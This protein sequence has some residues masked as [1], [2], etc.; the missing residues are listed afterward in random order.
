MKKLLGVVFMLMIMAGASLAQVQAGQGALAGVVQDST[1]AAIPGA[2]V[3]LSNPSIGFR[4]ETVTNGA[5]EYRFSPLTVIGG[6]SIQVTSP[7][8]AIA[9]VN[10][11][12]TSVGTIITE[13]VTLSVGKSDVIIEVKASGEEQVQTDTSSVSTVIDKTVWQD[14]PLEDRNQ[15]GFVG[16]TAGAAPS[17]AGRGFAVNGAR[18]GTGD[19]LVDGADNNDQG[20]GGGATGGAVTTISPDAIQEF[21]VISSTPPAEY[22]RAGGFATDTVLRS[23]SKT[24]HGSAF[25][26]N[27][28]QAITANN[29]ESGHNGLVD[30]LVRNQFGGSVGGRIY[31]D[32][33]F[34]YATA[35]FQRLRQG[36]PDAGIITTTP[37]FLNFVK[38]GAFETF[39][40]GTTQQIPDPS[41]LT[42]GQIGACPFNLGTSC[43]GV[44]ARSATLGP[45]FTQ[46]LAAEPS[47]FPLATSTIPNANIGEGLYTSGIT[48][49]VNVYGQVAVIDT[50]AY[51]ENRGSLKLDHKLTEKDQLSFTYLADLNNGNY[52]HGAGGSTPGV[53]ETTVG[54]AQLFG[55]N[56]TRT[57]SPTLIN[58]FKAGYLR[59][60]NNIDA[61]NAAGVPNI[62]PFD[63]L[64]TGF[65]ASSGLP[66][67][68]TEN[69]FSYE[70]S[71]TKVFGR[72]T[73]KVGFSFK[74]TR[75]GS[76]FYND[77]NGSIYPW[78]VEGLVTDATSDTDLDNYFYGTDENGNTNGYG[79]LA[80]A[81][82]SLNPT[83]NSA[84][85]PYRGYRANEF[86]AYVQDDF[87]V[88]ARLTLNY[89]VRWD[90]FG[91][92]HNFKAGV[93]SN[94]YFGTAT[95]PTPNGNP[96]LPNSSLLAGEQGASFQ[97][98]E[99]N[100]RST[101]WNRDTNNFAPRLGF[102][103]D[104][105]GTQK[106]VI[107]GGFGI[108]YDRLYNNVYE[109]IRFNAPFFVDNVGG[110]DEG[111]ASLGEP[112]RAGLYKVPFTGNAIL[113][114]T[115]AA[116]PRHVDQ[117]LVTAYYEQAH[118]GVETNLIKGFVLEVNY[119]G[120]W[121][122]KLVGI[123]NINTFAGRTACPVK[124]TPYAA[125][126]PCFIASQS[127]GGEGFTSA[128]PS[129][130]FGSDNFRTSSFSSNYNGGQVSLRKGFSHGFQISANYTYSKGLD[131]TSDV[132]SIKSGA[133][134]IT[135][136]YNPSYDYGPSDNDV[137][138][139]FILTANYV[140]ESKTHKYLLAGWGV[141]PIL[142]LQAGSPIDVIDGSSSYSPNKD[143]VFGVQRAVYV[144]TGSIK[145]AIQHGI[146]PSD[147][148]LKPGSFSGSD[149][150][151]SY[152]CPA[153]VAFC[154]APVGRNALTGPKQENLDMSVSKH[155]PIY[156]RYSLTL[157]AAFFDVFNHPEWGN[158]VANTNAGN[159]GQSTS[160]GNR[161]GQLSGRIDF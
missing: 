4:K 122:R 153:T 145:N 15:N 69:Q 157:Q 37:D 29:W 123:K 91:P 36:Q 141:S 150:V 12:E 62:V 47:S 14:S 127:T 124:T 77:V 102:A 63:S 49:P 82:A 66:Q 56:Y 84:P 147:G 67:Y 68:F 97:L 99:T 54:G 59:H 105:F 114:G 138:H 119:I 31:K 16:L 42:P 112:Q 89:G 1:K 98:A 106:L 58:V 140:S 113:S 88:S 70:D 109:N 74:R 129:H 78:S 76:A 39:M 3:V 103:Y 156:G 135:N 51:A 95:T 93:D 118:L 139:L 45:I 34:F 80:G 73:A 90:Y 19:F 130:A 57:F 72:H 87:K 43:P 120:T 71:L 61:V 125:G 85:D 83:T 41:G 117:N 10:D 132:F 158:P 23:G 60:V 148:Y 86:A 133:T 79:G 94:V 100:G 5:G 35:E 137:R 110:Y 136:P 46:L 108:G 27:R 104:A 52:N 20:L 38:T 33:T 75:N 126:S 26:Y 7:G 22:G 131:E 32:K 44:L 40:E 11:V 128:R 28:N 121:G 48:F 18:S 159:F 65:G 146:S 151:P 101:I 155:L 144:G 17:Y 92:P 111:E 21:R 50:T 116:V 64:Y 9:Q 13:N 81:S 25:E 161:V 154:D 53:A 149:G 55:V 134:G 30:H 24:W 96:F 115:G 143:G 142:S 160:A 107:R 152:K 8:F 2:K 6:Y